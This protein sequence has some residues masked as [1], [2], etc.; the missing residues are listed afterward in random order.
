MIK[1]KRKNLSRRTFVKTLSGGVLATTLTAPLS[2]MLNA[3]SA[4]SSEIFDIH[5]G[6]QGNWGRAP[7][8]YIGLQD[9]GGAIEY[10][11]IK[12]RPAAAKK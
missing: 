5:T 4:N 2:R 12:L 6:V 9:Y 10:R 1:N 8:G 7:K 11:N 3:Q